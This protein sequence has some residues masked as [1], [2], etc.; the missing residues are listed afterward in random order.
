[1]GAV[2]FELLSPGGG[3]CGSGT[4]VVPR[5]CGNLEIPA[6]SL[7]YLKKV[8]HS[9]E[10]KIHAGNTAWEEVAKKTKNKV[11]R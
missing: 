6:E 11:L 5:M 1:M 3:P 10:H 7:N 4:E 9:D 8:G 2:A